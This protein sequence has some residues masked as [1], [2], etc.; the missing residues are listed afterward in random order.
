[1]Q[2]QNLVYSKLKLRALE[3]QN[4]L[5][6]APMCQYSAVD[7]LVQTWHLQHYTERALGGAGL[8]IVEAT[9]VQPEGRISPADL[10]L[11]N[12]AQMEAFKPLVEAVHQAGSKIAVQLAHAGRK[13]STF[14]PWE[15]RG[16]LTAEAGA[17]Q[18]VSAS[19]LAFDSDFPQPKALE[20][21]EIQECIAAFAQAA[22]RA[23]K[24][25][26]DAVEI[27]A[28]H[29]YLLHQFLSPLSNKRKDRWGGSPENR[30]RLVKEVSAAIRDVSPEEAPLLIRLS[31][32]D[33]A[34]GGWTADETVTLLKELKGLGVDF[35][36]ISSGGLLPRAAISVGPGYQ[37]PFAIKVRQECDM[38]TGTVGLINEITQAETLLAA[39]CAD[40]ILL[41]R[42]LLRDPYFPL[43]NAPE[44]LRKSPKQYERAF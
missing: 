44:E 12:D 5:I 18:T 42:I 22:S 29:G 26:F 31:A 1:M 39:G 20:E 37:A 38:P 33:W 27:H 24:A 35:A 28:A 7:G 23:Y 10:G 11:W 17:W 41:G 40:A 30:F 16:A 34:E 13:A 25:G 19:D 32:S 8:I 14:V 4:R 6:M 36:D 21:T 15:G 3:L 2:K 9:A 43:R